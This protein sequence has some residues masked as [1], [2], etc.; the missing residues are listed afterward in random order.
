MMLAS[1]TGVYVAYR[2]PSR[3][4][5]SR[6]IMVVVTSERAA[7]NNPKLGA[8]RSVYVLDARLPPRDAAN[9][10]LD[11]AVCG[12]CPLRPANGGGCYVNIG[13]PGIHQLW[14]TA[15]GLDADAFGACLS[16]KRALREHGR[17]LRLTAYGDVGAVPGNVF[18]ALVRAAT[19][20]D[21][22][23]HGTGYTHDWRNWARWFARY[24]MASVATP[25]EAAEAQALGWRTFR[26]KLPDEALLENEGRCPLPSGELKKRADDTAR[27]REALDGTRV[28]CATCLK[29]SGTS[30]AFQ[31]HVAIDVHGATAAR[32]GYA[33]MRARSE[34]KLTEPSGTGS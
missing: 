8:M 32:A 4:D 28:T 5:R 26:A 2:G 31:G 12:A 15:I 29:C 14:S 13:I 23:F 9:K 11:L 24:F 10:G 18:E 1:K 16:V 22:V 6:E 21:G 17:G 30:G 25:E 33:A 3:F 27:L 7:G 34:A 20:G 19:D